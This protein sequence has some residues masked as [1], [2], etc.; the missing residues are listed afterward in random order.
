M[1]LGDR[2]FEIAESLLLGDEPA[3]GADVLEHQHGSRKLQ[4]LQELPV[5]TGDVVQAVLRQAQVIL[6]A[7]GG[8]LHQV[9]VDDVAHMLEI[10][11]EGENVG[12]RLASPSLR[13]SWLI[14]LR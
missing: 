6:D 9:L 7:L 12:R 11:G 14:E 5:H 13:A 8:E 1:L 10:D 3:G 4:M 2:T